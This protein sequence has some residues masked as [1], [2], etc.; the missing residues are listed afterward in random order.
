MSEDVFLEASLK[1]R[2]Q[3]ISSDSS[4]KTL[5]LGV[6][7]LNLE[8]KSEIEKHFEKELK[9]IHVMTIALKF[10]M[11]TTRF[12]INVTI[13]QDAIILSWHKK[14]VGALKPQR[15]FD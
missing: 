14:S 11:Q 10:L 15:F 9:K 4:K 3:N 5:Y 12:P 13:G 7:N 2:L 8:L 6:S 1:Y